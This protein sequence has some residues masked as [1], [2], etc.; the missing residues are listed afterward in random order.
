MYIYNG[1]LYVLLLKT[2]RYRKYIG[3]HYLVF[4]YIVG[5]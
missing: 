3:V 4:I 1:R 2:Y 5:L